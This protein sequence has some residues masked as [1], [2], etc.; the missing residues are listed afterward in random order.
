MAASRRRP[1]LAT[2][3]YHQMNTPTAA[4]WANSL[5]NSSHI[6][7]S[8]AFF[9]SG[10]RNVIVTTPSVRSTVIDSSSRVSVAMAATILSLVGYNPYRKFRAKPADYALVAAA[11]LVSLGLLIWAFAG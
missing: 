3:S 6:A 1:R 4:M 11:L 7:P 10:R 9:F 5:S 8:A 2:R